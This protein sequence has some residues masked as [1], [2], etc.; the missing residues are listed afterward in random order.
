MTTYQLTLDEN[1][2][3]SK[4]FLKYMKT[5]PFVSIS[6][7]GVANRKKMNG[8]D[9]AIKDIE[10]GRVSEAMTVEEFGEYLKQMRWEVENEI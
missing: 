3:Y 8:L 4:H 1:N 9:E 2:V 6:K 10:E 5:L 7:K